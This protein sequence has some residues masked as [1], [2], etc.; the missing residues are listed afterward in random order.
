MAII[1]GR[2]LIVKWDGTAIAGARSCELNVQSDTIE[3]SSPTQGLWRDYIAGRKGWTVTCGQLVTEVENNI[4]MVGERVT[5]RFG[6]RDDTDYVEGYA[7]VT[8]WKATGNIGS[9]TQG[10]FSFQG[11]GPLTGVNPEQQNT[12]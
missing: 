4:D 5:L 7:I 3:V 1:H 8:S 2:N 6:K 11:C 9:L 10:S 12:Q